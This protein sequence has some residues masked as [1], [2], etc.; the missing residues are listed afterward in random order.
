MPE[1]ERGSENKK[2][3]R[4]LERQISERTLAEGRETK[5]RPWST[6]LPAVMANV[7]ASIFL[8]VLAAGLV[9]VFQCFLL[10]FFNK[11]QFLAIPCDCVRELENGNTER[12][13]T[14]RKLRKDAK[15]ARKKVI[16]FK[17][18]S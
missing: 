5:M 12:S 4:A 11:N 3:D 16:K 10:V 6:V 7:S 9:C 14:K 15:I 1:L 17:T 8:T 18:I 13:V 2:K